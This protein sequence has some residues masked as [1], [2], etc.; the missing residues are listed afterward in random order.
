M[1]AEQVYASECEA[2]GELA[3]L[4]AK[5]VPAFRDKFDFSTP[6]QYD[7]LADIAFLAAAAVISKRRSLL[8][9]AKVRF[10]RALAA[11]KAAEAAKTT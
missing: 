5:M 9:E 6:D 11:E 1:K 3:G 10:D 8:D 4:A 7:K 2:A